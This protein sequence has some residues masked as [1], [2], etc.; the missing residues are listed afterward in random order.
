[1][2][3]RHEEQERMIYQSAES[4]RLGRNMSST[5]REALKVQDPMIKVVDCTLSSLNFTLGQHFP[6]CSSLEH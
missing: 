4:L 2:R 1:M 5:E 6:R 3:L